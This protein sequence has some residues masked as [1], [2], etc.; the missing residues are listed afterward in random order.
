M[1]DPVRDAIVATLAGVPRIGRVHDRE[2]YA[3][4]SKGLLALYGWTDPDTA[5]AALRGWFVSL[6]S[7]VYRPKRVGRATAL[8]EWRIVGLMGFDDDGSS[9]LAMAD[10]A[11]AVVRAF[12]ADPTLDGAVSRLSDSHAGEGAPVGAQILRLEPVMFAGVLTHRA[13]LSLITE[14]FLQE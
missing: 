1:T 14:R 8:A 3:K 2:R 6:T 7:E 12:R 5:S 9:E 4:E 13:T 11:R 10:L